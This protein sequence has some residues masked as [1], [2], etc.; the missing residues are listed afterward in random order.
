MEHYK[1]FRRLRTL[2]LA[3]AVVILTL[4]VM[5]HAAQ[6]ITTPNAAFISY[7]LPASPSNSAPITPVVGQAVLVMGTDTTATDCGSPGVGEVSMLRSAGTTG[8]FTTPP[9]LVW[10][11]V[12]PP[13]ISTTPG[14]VTGGFSATAGTHIV[15]LDTGQRRVD[16]QVHNGSSFVVHNRTCGPATGNVTLIW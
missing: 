12:E 14:T 4:S 6:V 1:K 3:A 15:S 11:G 7:N 2:V 8:T 13:S 10:T 5:V 9:M 16:L